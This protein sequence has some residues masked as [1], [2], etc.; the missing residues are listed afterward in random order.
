M[1]TSDD[2]SDVFFCFELKKAADYLSTKQVN[3]KETRTKHER[4]PQK[5]ALLI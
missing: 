2:Y 1:K 3:A 4:N 5:Y